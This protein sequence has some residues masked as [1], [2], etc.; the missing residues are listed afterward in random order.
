MSIR[1][2]GKVAI[3]TGA[4]NAGGQRP[5]HAVLLARQVGTAGPRPLTI[6][7][8]ATV[9]PCTVVER[10]RLMLLWAGDA[11]GSVRWPRLV[12]RCGLT[13]QILTPSNRRMDANHFSEGWRFRNLSP[14]ERRGC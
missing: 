5:V 12:E 10:D 14:T 4:G 8:A 13:L 3:V 7:K 6:L 1:F 2:D 11:Q 9:K